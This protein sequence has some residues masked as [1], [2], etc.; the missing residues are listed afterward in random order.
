MFYKISVYSFEQN[1]QRRMHKKLDIF[2][3]YIRNL[4]FKHFNSMI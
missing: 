1:W 2:A 3:K 4:K